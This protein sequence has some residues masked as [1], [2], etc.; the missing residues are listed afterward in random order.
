MDNSTSLSQVFEPDTL[1]IG[2]IDNP[3]TVQEEEEDPDMDDL[4]HVDSNADGD[5]KDSENFDNCK[6][7]IFGDELDGRQTSLKESTRQ[8]SKEGD[9]AELSSPVSIRISCHYYC[10]CRGPYVMYLKLSSTRSYIK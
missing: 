7:D 8:E 4:D 1:S 10:N 9:S 5:H 3:G 6:D 2:S